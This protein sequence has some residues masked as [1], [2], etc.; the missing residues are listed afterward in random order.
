[1]I[2]RWGLL[3][4]RVL[5]L[6]GGFALVRRV[7][8]PGGGS[9]CGGGWG[10]GGGQLGLLVGRGAGGG[11]CVRA[12]GGGGGLGWRGLRVEGEVTGRRGGDLR[13]SLAGGGGRFRGGGVE[14][15]DPAL[16]ML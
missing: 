12:A 13:F 1:M 8:C 5:L 15:P 9:V 10:G 14:L 16:G 3:R 2:G 6:A 4:D 11:G 7:W